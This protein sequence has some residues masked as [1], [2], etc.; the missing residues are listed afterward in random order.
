MKIIERYENL[1]PN[2]K[3]LVYLCGSILLGCI[4]SGFWE[5]VLSPALEFCNHAL[6]SLLGTLS[7]SYVDSLYNLASRVLYERSSHLILFSIAVILLFATLFLTDIKKINSSAQKNNTLFLRMI[8]LAFSLT[9]YYH[10]VKIQTVGHISTFTRN[11]IEIVRPYIDEASYF[12]LK[13]EFYQMSTET[14]YKNLYK[15]LESIESKNKTIK[16]L[17]KQTF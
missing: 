9:L 7:K 13:S 4:G 12:K 3:I 2:K 15:K 14:D 8:L 10:F 17:P 6:I 1:S 5:K 11:S 16:L